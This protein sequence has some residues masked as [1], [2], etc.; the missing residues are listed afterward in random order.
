MG[1]AHS[2]PRLE[3]RDALV[4]GDEAPQA[5]RVEPAIA[6]RD[7]FERDVVGARQPRRRAL[8]QARQLAAVRLGQVA[9]AGANLLFDQ[10]EIVEQPFPGRR[11][12]L[13]GGERRLQQLAGRHQDAFVLGQALEQPVAARTQAAPRPQLVRARQGLAMALHLVGAVE[14]RAQRGLV[15]QDFANSAR[16]FVTPP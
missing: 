1:T 5:F 4:R 7:R 2:S 12:R 10:V 16:D 9:L 8:Q 11:D 3:R 15:D 13:A 14:R 6:V